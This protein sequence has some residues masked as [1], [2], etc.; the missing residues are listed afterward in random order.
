MKKTLKII[1]LIL[2]AVIIILVADFTVRITVRND[3]WSEFDCRYVK[4]V[5][6]LGFDTFVKEHNKAFPDDQLEATGIEYWS[7]IRSKRENDVYYLYIDFDGDNGYFVGTGEFV[8]LTMKTEGDIP[9]LRDNPN[10]MFDTSDLEFYYK[11][12]NGEWVEER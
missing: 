7:L 1:A 2:A 12:G 8:I 9:E 6:E 3:K 5:T 11:N 10:V 4:T